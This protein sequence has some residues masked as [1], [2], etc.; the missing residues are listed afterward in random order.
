MGRNSVNLGEDE[1]LANE[2]RKY[3]VLYNKSLPEYKEKR[4]KANAWK[5]VGVAL[6]LEEGNLFHRIYRKLFVF[7]FVFAIALLVSFLRWNIIHS[8]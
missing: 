3:P 6:G 7:V 8:S 2:V 4:A 1:A 5:K